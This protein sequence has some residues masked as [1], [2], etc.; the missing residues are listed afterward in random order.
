MRTGWGEEDS[1]MHI[2]GVQLERG[3]KSTHSHNDT[4][5]LELQIAGEEEV[6]HY[7]EQNAAQASYNA[8]YENTKDNI[9]AYWM[10]LIMFIFLF[11]L[12]AMITLEFIDKDKR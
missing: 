10:R 12:L 6:R 9:T 7:I 1:Y 8:D 5:H 4:G 2:H 3:E 11:A